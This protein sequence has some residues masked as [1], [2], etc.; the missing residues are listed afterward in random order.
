MSRSS[1]TGRFEWPIVKIVMRSTFM[2]RFTLIEAR[3]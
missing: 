2:V 1:S 3:R